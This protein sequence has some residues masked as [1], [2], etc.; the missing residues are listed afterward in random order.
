M[1]K[2]TLRILKMDCPSEEQLIRMKLDGLN[3]IR[4]L[5][6]DIP[7]R[8][9]VVVHSSGENEILD[10]I[11]SLDLDSSIVDSVDIDESPVDVKES[12]EKR[13]LWM[14]L[15][16]NLFFFLLELISGFIAGSMGLVADSLDMLA[17]SFV[18]GLALFAVGGTILRKKRIAKVSGY[19]QM[20]LAILGLAEVIR[21]FIGI[22]SL[23][24]FRTMIIVSL[25]ALGGNAACLW[26]L[27]KS[28]SREAHMQA[29]MI[30]TS[31]DVI[32][33]LGVITAGVVV[34]LTN[35]SYPD[36]IIGIAV[37]ILVARGALRILKL[38]D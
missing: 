15:G 14:V 35:S 24:E 36:L 29:S 31:N 2:T 11:N 38:S 4:S 28:K 17:D 37:F 8:K 13:L 3:N 34:Y 18:Y 12:T 32:A 26:L 22:E 20:V 33:N 16:I 6:F 30:F 10:K 27:Q 1:R 21:R 9:L 19:F 7:G 23:P 25:M 5:E